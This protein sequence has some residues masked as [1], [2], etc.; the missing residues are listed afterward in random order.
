[1]LAAGELDLWSMDLARTF[2]V[3]L[4]AILLC[5]L[6]GSPQIEQILGGGTIGILMGH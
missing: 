3:C 6:K 4:L 2:I 1:M 5:P